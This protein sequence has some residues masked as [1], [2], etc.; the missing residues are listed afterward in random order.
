MHSVVMGLIRDLNTCGSGKQLL[1]V[2]GAIFE[3]RLR[4]RISLLSTESDTV[5]PFQE[6]H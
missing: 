5:K 1:L 3:L 4:I 6:K 2:E